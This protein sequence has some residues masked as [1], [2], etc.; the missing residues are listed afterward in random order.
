MLL[1]FTK[2]INSRVEYTFEFIL[3]TL[4]GFTYQLTTNEKEYTSY[5][6]PTLNYSNTTLKSNDI[7]LRPNGLLELEEI[8]NCKAAIKSENERIEIVLTGAQ[9]AEHFDVFAATFYLVTRYEEYVDFQADEHGRYNAKHSILFR[10]HLLQQPIVDSW[11][12]N[13]KER[14]IKK[15]SGLAFTQK[16]FQA[17]ITIDVDQAYAF[18]NRGLFKNVLA[19]F[20]N[21]LFVNLP[22]L[23]SQINTM[24][25]GKTDAFDTF[26]YL[27][28]IQKKSRLPFIYFFN[29][30]NASRFDK[31]LPITNK[32]FSKLVKH[33]ST[34]AAAGIHP[35]YFANEK[36]ESFWI[37]K[38]RLTLLTGNIILKS[39]QH[40]LKFTLPKTYRLLLQAG[41]N[42]DY[43][44][45]YAT[46]PGF[47]SG[48]CTPYYWFDLE[49][50][51]KTPLKI[52]PITFM[53]GSLGEY[54]KMQP[55][56]ALQVIQNLSNEVKKHNGTYISIWHNHTVNNQFFWKG[57][58]GVF[59]N[60]IAYLSN[61]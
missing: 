41:I 10:N 13:L 49:G 44:M 16:Q 30:G 43:S 34:Y 27:K 17:L 37:E 48:T 45:G 54:L 18:K 28:E 36:P 40:Y 50:N 32:A 12:L 9:I 59:E 20:K 2:Y 15:Y 58:R 1:V 19:F 31:N 24:A 6:G 39:R 23:S 47:R 5:T 4:C 35:S 11:A 25:F 53:E 60:S 57:W 42:E 7:E 46:L 33:I 14:I 3:K 52:F 21:T 22:F 38:E 26:N 8:I 29:L 55:S 56:D 61:D 51:K